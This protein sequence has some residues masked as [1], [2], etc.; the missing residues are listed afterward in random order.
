[1]LTYSHTARITCRYQHSSVASKTQ[2]DDSLHQF[3]V[4][5]ALDSVEQKLQT[6]NSM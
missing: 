1:M 5:S 4:H 6:T 2:K 3:I